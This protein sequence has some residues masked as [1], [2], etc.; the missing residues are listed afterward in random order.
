MDTF[1][2]ITKLDLPHVHTVNAFTEDPPDLRIEEILS[3]VDPEDTVVVFT[4]LEYGSINQLFFSKLGKYKFWLL[5]G[6]NLQLL[7]ELMTCEEELNEDTITAALH[8]ARDGIKFMN[9]IFADALQQ[10]TSPTADD[11]LSL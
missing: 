6:M 4:D 5:T 8:Q 1:S 2:F 11:F 7:L 9:P 10:P 3:S